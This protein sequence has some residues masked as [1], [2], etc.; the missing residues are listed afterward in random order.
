MEFAINNTIQTREPG[1]RI[2]R[3]ARK[4]F[5]G[6]ITRLQCRFLTSVD[7]Y[8]YELF[9]VI[10][11][12]Y[13][14]TVISLHILNKIVVIELYV[15]FTSAN[16]SGPSSITV[17]ANTGT[18]AK[19]ESPIIEFCGGFSGLF[20]SKYYG[21]PETSM[22]RHSS[23]S[24]IDLNFKGQYLSRY[25]LE[26][27]VGHLGNKRTNDLLLSTGA[28]KGTSNTMLE[29]DNEGTNK[30]GDAS[31]EKGTIDANKGKES[32]LEPI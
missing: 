5:Q 30:E 7:S 25:Q 4:S 1:T 15:E 21:V 11:E 23:V 26:Y 10:S 28:D 22:G 24:G 12:T 29:G 17:T 13:L 27:S 16:R 31:E 19:V 20:Q 6:R 9:D 14:E 8:K 18:K 32:E 2:K 3:K